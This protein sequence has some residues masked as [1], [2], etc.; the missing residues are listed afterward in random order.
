MTERSLLAEDD[1]VRV[2]AID[3]EHAIRDVG[4]DQFMAKPFTMNQL[5]TQA[6]TL[7]SERAGQL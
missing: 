2:L 6:R 1:P 4:V 3:D 5:V 7:T